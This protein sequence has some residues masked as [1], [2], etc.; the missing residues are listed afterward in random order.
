MSHVDKRL[1]FIFSIKFNAFKP[2]IVDVYYQ[3]DLQKSKYE[4]IY[5]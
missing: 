1:H 4:L 3:V 5:C 2:R